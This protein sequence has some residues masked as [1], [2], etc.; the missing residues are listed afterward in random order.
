MVFKLL[1]LTCEGIGW[2]RI[3]G[4]LQY[5]FI[6]EAAEYFGIWLILIAALGDLTEMAPKPSRLVAVFLFAMPIF[7]TFLLTHD[8]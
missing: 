4:C 6:E 5:N 7:W 1:P 8:A 3:Q 2:L